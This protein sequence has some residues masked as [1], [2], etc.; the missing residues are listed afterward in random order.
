MGDIIVMVTVAFLIFFATAALLEVIE[1][2]SF[3]IRQTVC[4]AAAVNGRITYYECMGTEE[5]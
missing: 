2:E 1:R 4:T 5:P 3:K